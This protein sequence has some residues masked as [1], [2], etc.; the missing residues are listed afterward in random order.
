MVT[1]YMVS[2]QAVE[3]LQSRIDI[4]Q[5]YARPFIDFWSR[6][7]ASEPMERFARYWKYM[8][9]AEFDT[10]TGTASAQVRAFTAEDA[11]LIAR[12]L[13]SLSEDLI[14]E[15][16]HRPQRDAV[17]YAEVE[18][19][20]AEDRVKQIRAELSAYREKEGLIEPTTSIVLS[21]ATVASTLRGVIAQLNTEVATLQKQKIAANSP[22]MQTLQFRIKA[23]EEQLKE[24]EAK[25]STVGQPGS[26]SIAQAVA[27][28]E[29]LD[30]ERQF[31]QAMLTS[32]MQSLEQA[33]SNAITQRIYVTPFV[34]PALPQMSVYPKRFVA[35]LTVAGACLLLWTI[36]LLLSRSIREHLT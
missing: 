16:A 18:V 5:L 9:T 24:V 15:V 36:A 14:N 35:I 3:E 8:T 20:R 4:R 2:R 7:D 11:F 30:L 26:S 23:T 32:T 28:Y 34:M 21:N 31:A 25:I 13:L 12:T 29:Q 22:Q 33:R 6:L 10:V 17:R 27:R 19:K 1:E